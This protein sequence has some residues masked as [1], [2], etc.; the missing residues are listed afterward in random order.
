MLLALVARSRDAIVE[1]HLEWRTD[2]TLR[3]GAGLAYYALFT[4]VPFLALTAALAWQ[5]FGLV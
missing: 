1:T 3:L 2:R 5:V 4:I